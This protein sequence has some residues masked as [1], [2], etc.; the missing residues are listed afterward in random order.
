[1]IMT[2]D[3]LSEKG[4]T[5]N[6]G[7]CCYMPRWSK[8]FTQLTHSIFKTRRG[9]YCYILRYKNEKLSAQRLSVLSKSTKLLS[10]GTG[11]WTHGSALSLCF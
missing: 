7:I 11:I 9:T 4:V 5:G 10:D 2:N 8:R 1:M 6:V 3:V